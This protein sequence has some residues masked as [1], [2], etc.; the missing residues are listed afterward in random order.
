MFVRIK[1]GIIQNST[2]FWKSKYN[3]G[4]NYLRKMKKPEI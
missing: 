4:L 3:F 1:L 2:M